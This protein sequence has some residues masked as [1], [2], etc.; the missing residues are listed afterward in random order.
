MEFRFRVERPSA[1]AQPVAGARSVAEVR[2][3]EGKAGALLAVVRDAD[4]RR[5]DDLAGIAV[6][7]NLAETR[8]LAELLIVAYLD[9]RHSVLRAERLHELLVRGLGAVLRE[10]ADLRLLRVEG[11]GDAVK[12][13]D[14]AVRD[15]R[16][17]QDLFDRRDQIGDLLFLLL[18]DHNFLVL[19]VGHDSMRCETPLRLSQ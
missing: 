9:E 5:A 11:L 3:Q 10:E 1:T 2:L 4:A 17:L 18:L 19:N 14:D 15:H 12:A 7:V 8:P 6:L 16:I 13:T